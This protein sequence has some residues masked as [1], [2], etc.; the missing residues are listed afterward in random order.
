MTTNR[1]PPPPV[2]F[3]ATIN[4]T[5]LPSGTELHRIYPEQVPGNAFSTSADK[6]H[7]FSP[8][9]AAGQAVPVL[10]ACSSVEVAIHE[11]FF[12]DAADRGGGI[13]V[14]RAKAIEGK[15]YSSCSTR[16]TL[17]LATLHAAALARFGLSA[18][19][20]TRSPSA[21]YAHTARWA[22]AIH[23]NHPK[24][25]GIEWTSLRGAREPAFML[26]GDRVA[27]EDLIPLGNETLIRSCAA[28]Y[29]QILAGAARLGVRVHRGA[30]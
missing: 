23:A 13:R 12:F 6:L 19:Q 30:M 21:C 2:P 1:V 24:I 15:C 8:I 14:L 22:E 18:E 17:R 29:A 5:L 20:L 3:P 27:Q 10:Y 25:E 26:F 7:R 4:W 16:R 9:F 28:L 11:T